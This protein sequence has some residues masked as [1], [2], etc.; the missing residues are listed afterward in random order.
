MSKAPLAGLALFQE[1]LL[2]LLWEESDP[3][4]VRGALLADPRL[5]DFHDYIAEMEPEMLEVAAE[6]ARKWGVGGEPS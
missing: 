2:R 1:Q 4:A 6:L 3:A 5:A